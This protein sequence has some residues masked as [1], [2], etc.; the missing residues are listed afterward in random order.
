M[1]EPLRVLIVSDSHADAQR[2]IDELERLDRP[3]ACERVLE[4]MGLR[5]ALERSAIDLVLCAATM[6]GYGA[7]AALALLRELGSDVPLIALTRIASVDQA[8]ELMRAG[9]RD[10]LLVEQLER[11]LPAVRRELVASAT[12]RSERR[13]SAPVDSDGARMRRIFDAGVLAIHVA[14]FGG[15]L[16]QANDSFLS[17]IGYSRAELES[18]RLHLDAVVPKEWRSV[19]LDAE[20]T[21]RTAGSCALREG[22]YVRKDGARVQVLIASAALGDNEY[23]GYAIDISERKR[24]EAGLRQSD[25]Q[26][27][28]AQ[29]LDA[30]G[31]LAGGIA[32]EYNNLMSVVLTYTALIAQDC[33]AEDPKQADLTEIRLAAEQ[34]VGLTQQLLAFSRHQVMRPVVSDVNE[35][36]SGLRQLLEALLGDEIALAYDCAN[37]LGKVLVDPKQLAQVVMNLAIH[38]RETM[39]NGGRFTLSTSNV[40]LDPEQ[41]AERQ[42]LV[43]GKHVLLCAADT[44][45]GMDQTVRARAF[46]PFVNHKDRSTASGLGLATALGIARQSGGDLWVES[47]P[48]R[49]SIF[50]LCLPV[51]S[52]GTIR[53]RARRS[54]L[55][56]RP[57]LPAQNGRET[58][59]LVEHDDKV[60]QSTLAVLRRLG[61]H[62]L[63]AQSGAAALALGAQHG[64]PIHLLLTNV[65][66]PSM[67]GTELADRLLTLRPTLKVVYLCG[68][69]PDAL[70]RPGAIDPDIPLLAKPITPETL[71]P[72][73]RKALDS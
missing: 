30:V 49:G 36:L 9:A 33:P 15:A 13:S 22:E 39:P 52:S 8:V 41:A 66:T 54:D 73:I 61:Y 47:E 24:A 18:G 67:S 70:N 3:L 5:I 64:G 65:A 37:E 56:P 29:T 17:L 43:P 4:G 53:P 46:E 10:V 58:I 40:V 71:G 31:R 34:A 44:S 1:S 69:A 25:A 26:Q 2:I 28:H 59:L 48:G 19:E 35:L 60:R 55:P 14:R 45:A 20:Q 68:Y 32:H 62:T 63:E 42:G 50:K 11:L 6:Q 7:L 57:S 16:V 21:L 23:V 38:A 12:R 51:V 27:R 72:T